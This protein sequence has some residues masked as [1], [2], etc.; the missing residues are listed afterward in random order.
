MNRVKEVNQLNNEHKPTLAG[1]KLSRRE[2]LER[3]SPFG[4]VELDA[5]KCTACGLCA[6][7]CPTSALTVASGEKADSFKL[8]YKQN[9]C[10]ACSECVKI[11]PEK[12]LRVERTLKM[13]KPGD[14]TVL[15]KID[16]VRCAACGN[17]V[18]PSTMIN[19]IQASMTAAGQLFDSQ[20]I[21]CP[22]CKLKAQFG[23]PGN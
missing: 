6:I 1:Q 4:R 11:C 21:F 23:Q 10:L 5:A 20:S 14:E 3:F 8:Y 19:K 22:E 9:L 15:L 2:L 16:I 13:D 7:E 18:G 12:C 17:P